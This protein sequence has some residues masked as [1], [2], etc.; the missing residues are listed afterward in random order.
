MTEIEER[1]SIVE[2]ITNKNLTYDCRPGLS[3]FAVAFGCVSPRCAET[4]ELSKSETYPCVR[5]H[6][7][8][9]YL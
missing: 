4:D 3:K 1:S 5:L 7:Q 2:A 8:L 9:T 6:A